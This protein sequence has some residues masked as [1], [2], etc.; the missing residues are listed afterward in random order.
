VSHDVHTPS[1]TVKNATMLALIGTALTTGLLLWNF[2][3]D[4]LNAS[5]GLVPGVTVLTS[6]IYALGSFSVAVFFYVFR[7][8]Q[9]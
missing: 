6:F 9:T 1:M 5:R 8:K 2:V 7:E 3:A 4:L